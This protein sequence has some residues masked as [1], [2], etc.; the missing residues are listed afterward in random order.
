MD[1]YLE[2]DEL[3][4]NDYWPHG[5]LDNNF[6]IIGENRFFNT[7]YYASPFGYRIEDVPPRFKRRLH[8]IHMDHDFKMD[9]LDSRQ[10][11]HTCK[12]YHI[13]D[14]HKCIFCA[15]LFIR[16]FTAIKYCGWAPTCFNCLNK[17]PWERC[18]YH[19]RPKNIEDLPPLGINP[20]VF[21]QEELDSFD[22]FSFD[23][24]AES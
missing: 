15:N 18:P 17:L 20:K 3:A 7:L 24:F 10:P 16:D 8:S 2:V 11:C 22:P 9:L 5:G 4:I 23:L 12:G 19:I 13:I 6:H 1:I 14:L 21:T